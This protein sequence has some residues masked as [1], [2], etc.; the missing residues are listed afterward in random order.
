MNKILSYKDIEWFKSI[1]IKENKKYMYEIEICFKSINKE[2]YLEILND[3]KYL[4]KKDVTFYEYIKYK[5]SYIYIKREYN[6]N[7]VY[8]IKRVMKFKYLELIPSCIYLNS[9]LILN[10]SFNIDNKFE[11]IK[12]HKISFFIKNF[13]FNLTTINDNKYNIEVK[14]KNQKDLKNIEIIYF[15]NIRNIIKHISY[16]RYVIHRLYL[17]K[18]KNIMKQPIPL[19]NLIEI[20]NNFAVTP[21]LDGIRSLMLINEY[22]V[23]FIIKFGNDILFKTNL[24][25]YHLT[26]I[27]IDG[28]LIDDKVF[29]AI[30]IVFYKNIELDDYNLKD[31]INILKK[32]NF[33]ETEYNK[34]I[35]YKIKNYYFD[36]IYNICKKL[37]ERKYYYTINKIKKQILID[38][39][40]FNSISENYKNCIIYKWKPVITFDFRILKF[41]DHNNKIFWKLYCYTY[42]NNYIL[43]PIYKYSK[44]YVKPEIDGLYKDNDIIEFKFNKTDDSFCPIKLRNDK[45]KPNFINVAMDNWD[46]LNNNIIF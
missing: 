18:I 7:S 13:K 42:E 16:D 1:N 21:K 30:D 17:Y 46:C 9:V 22:G 44:L 12:K 45:I 3:F 6:N 2:T 32:L 40:I 37:I 19:K 8:K 27:I 31:R 29:Y 14:I 41:K 26:N 33:T 23:V 20:N 28:E 24:I 39:L 38:G 36:N 35:Y 43:F 10:K 25:C 4:E 15:N 34:I 11:K 5:K